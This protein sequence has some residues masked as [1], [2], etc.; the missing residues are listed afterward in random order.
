MGNPLAFIE[1]TSFAWAQTMSQSRFDASLWKEL[2]NRQEKSRSNLSPVLKDREKGGNRPTAKKSDPPV[3]ES[4]HSG[5]SE[6]AQ[7]GASGKSPG[8]AE[9]P[10]IR[11]KIFDEEFKAATE[12]VM[13]HDSSD[14]IPPLHSLA[15]G[16]PR[17][18]LF[19][20]IT[21][22][23][24]R[25]VLEAEDFRYLLQSIANTFEAQALALE[26][27]DAMGNSFRP[28]VHLNLDE[29][30][31]E[32]LYFSVRDRY[33]EPGG[34][35]Q[36]G[37]QDFCRR[38]P[39]LKKRFSESFLKDKGRM[40][41]YHDGFRPYPMILVLFF[42]EEQ[43][44]EFDPAMV[45]EVQNWLRHVRPL[46]FDMAHSY[47]FA[48]DRRILQKAFRTTRK[49]LRSAQ[50]SER[51]IVNVEGVREHPGRQAFFDRLQELV[52]S[53]NGILGIRTGVAEVFLFHCQTAA[54]IEQNLHSLGGEFGFRLKIR[55]YPLE[56]RAD[57][58]NNALL[59][60]LDPEKSA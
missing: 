47:S 52:S 44:Q 10:S 32:N 22:L 25:P 2:Q 36:L 8:P 14:P 50:P 18:S 1:N 35:I 12:Q 28:A 55:R 40:A 43:K 13:E 59:L 24:Q 20:H 45:E 39:F 21:A 23:H 6:A 49:F 11:G 15:G 41:I 34:W 4:A 29:D 48:E 7:T 26:P 19:R 5:H 53:R 31:V 27:L 16:A 9:L 58:Q 51:W 56:Y 46:I 3:S 42:K 60:L 54:E 17:S 57:K 30:T 33:I 38:D 37:L